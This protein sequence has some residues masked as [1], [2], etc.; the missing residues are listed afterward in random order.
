MATSRKSGFFLRKKP[1]SP[2][3]E[4]AGNVLR[5]TPSVSPEIARKPARHPA[6]AAGAV[7]RV[8]ACAVAR[9]G[10]VGVWCVCVCRGVRW[11]CDG[12]RVCVCRGVPRAW[13][14]CV[15]AGRV[16]GGGAA[17]FAGKS[18]DPLVF[19]PCLQEG[20]CI[21]MRGYAA[22]RPAKTLFCK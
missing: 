14:R 18:V 9:V 1:R 3:G 12:V 20:V 4:R 6:L 15:R 16:P 13:R 21:N 10:R 8:Y 19:P 11:A 22:R 5:T 7:S 2:T 17:D